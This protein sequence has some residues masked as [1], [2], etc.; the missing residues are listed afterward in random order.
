MSIEK[1][2]FLNDIN[3][4][5]LHFFSSYMSTVSSSHQATTTNNGI[6]LIVMLF[7][8]QNEENFRFGLEKSYQKSIIDTHMSLTSE[9]QHQNSAI[10]VIAKLN[11]LFVNDIDLTALE[12]DYGQ[13]ELS[14]LISRSKFDKFSLIKTFNHMSKTTSGSSINSNKLPFGK[15]FV[16][17]RYTHLVCTGD[18]NLNEI[19]YHEVASIEKDSLVDLSLLPLA[20]RA[21]FKHIFETIENGGGEWWPSEQHL[22]ELKLLALDS[23]LVQ[24]EINRKRDE[25]IR[26]GIIRNSVRPNEVKQLLDKNMFADI[27]ELEKIMKKIE[28]ELSAYYICE[29]VAD[30][31][32]IT[33]VEELA[34][35]QA[36]A[37]ADLCEED[38]VKLNKIDALASYK[39]VQRYRQLICELLLNLIPRQQSSEELAKS[40]HRFYLIDNG[41]HYK[42][43]IPGHDLLENWSQQ[44]RDNESFV[45]IEQQLPK[46]SNVIENI[47][48]RQNYIF[49]KDLM[50]VLSKNNNNNN[51]NSQNRSS[52]S[53]TAKP[54][55]TIPAKQPPP[56]ASA[57]QSIAKK[58]SNS[59]KQQ[60]INPNQKYIN[61]L[62]ADLSNSN[63]TDQLPSFS[64]SFSAPLCYVNKFDSNM[65]QPPQPTTATSTPQ[66]TLVK[67]EANRAAAHVYEEISNH[68]I[69]SSG[70]AFESF[71]VFSSTK[72]TRDRIIVQEID[73]MFSSIRDHQSACLKAHGELTRKAKY[74]TWGY[75]SG[76]R[77]VKAKVMELPFAED[78]SN[79]A[80]KVE[81]GASFI[82]E[83]L[84]LNNDDDDTAVE[85]VFVRIDDFLNQ[86]ISH[87]LQRSYSSDY[88]NIFG[89]PRT[90]VKY[91][92]IP[93]FGMTKSTTNGSDGGAHLLNYY[94]YADLYMPGLGPD[95]IMPSSQRDMPGSGPSVAGDFRVAPYDL[96]YWSILK[97][98]EEERQ[99]STGQFLTYFDQM[100]ANEWSNSIN[101]DAVL[102]QIL[103]KLLPFY[104][105]FM[106]PTFWLF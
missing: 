88:L 92:K 79:L 100:H 33:S 27:P 97:L 45:Q 106:L 89:G 20:I 71:D 32:R 19:L 34:G 16:S 41:Y 98:L 21:Q 103:S 76:K 82:D 42:C 77:H 68:H 54:N 101:S 73:R 96:R 44:L 55:Q 61:E 12:A 91:V 90:R 80:K 38:L 36:E 60:R 94:N 7:D 28:L 30:V 6:N 51:N 65:A 70:G 75:S 63:N 46:T 105:Y 64:E 53:E 35:S 95:A 62:F 84:L 58:S 9:K 47:Q 83:T 74:S 3:D 15:Y 1:I 78:L 72:D 102:K 11:V 23:H 14:D 39:C 86:D 81:N 22:P 104:G 93:G 59:N 18:P 40:N 37:M 25:L 10:N 48:K 66:K 57:A 69:G 87:T 85:K 8:K 31:K 29:R 4:Y 17:V 49:N 56:P 99:N 24:A 26:E 43:V 5:Q 52:R 13:C 50:N 2:N 67:Q